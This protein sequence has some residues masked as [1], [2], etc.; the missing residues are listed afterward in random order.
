MVFSLGSLIIIYMKK[1]LFMLFMLVGILLMSCDVK[2][3]NVAKE[4]VSL[5]QEIPDTMT[6][7]EHAVANQVGALKAEKLAEDTFKVT[8]LVS[9]DH[10]KKLVN[11]EYL[12]V[13]ADS[14]PM[15]GVVSSHGQWLVEPVYQE[16]KPLMKDVFVGELHWDY[17]DSNVEASAYSVLKQ[18]VYRGRP[19]G[20]FTHDCEI[21]PIDYKGNLAGFLKK[22]NSNFGTSLYYYIS[23]T[24][25]GWDA[26]TGQEIG[27]YPRF[28]YYQIKGNIL[29]LWGGPENLEDIEGI[30][31]EDR[32]LYSVNL[33][34]GKVLENTF[35]LADRFKID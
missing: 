4:T 5:V 8:K 6:T 33:Q 12:P 30:F 15:V 32:S 7:E 19:L 24:G 20:N 9:V 25:K 35:V 16:V 18:I 1:I 31:P 11:A 2:D 13:E 14:I 26:W 28:E 27:S 3:S 22:C 21:I 34:T 10:Y 29:T 23:K 17:Y